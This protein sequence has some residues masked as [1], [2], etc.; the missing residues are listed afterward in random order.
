MASLSPCD[1]GSEYTLFSSDH[2]CLNTGYQPMLVALDNMWYE[3]IIHLMEFHD[4]YNA[5]YICISLYRHYDKSQV[6]CEI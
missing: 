5:S 6:Y 4:I 1:V 2:Y 3:N